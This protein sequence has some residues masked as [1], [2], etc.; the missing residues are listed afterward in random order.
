MK[1][2]TNSKKCTEVDTS[3]I[4]ISWN[5]M[6]LDTFGNVRSYNETVKNMCK[7]ID[8]MTNIFLT[9]T[10]FEDFLLGIELLTFNSLLFCCR[11]LLFNDR[12]HANM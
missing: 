11:C 7:P 3:E 9:G 10:D 6:K 2:I 5:D 4:Y 8:G 12:V 1:Q